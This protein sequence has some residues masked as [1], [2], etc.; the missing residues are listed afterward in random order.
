MIDAKHVL[1]EEQALTETAASENILDFLAAQDPGIGGGT[2]VRV[3]FQV[4]TELDSA[5]DGASLTIHVVD[6]TAAPVDGSSTV[7]VSSEAIAEASLVAGYRKEL[8][9]PAEAHGRILGLYYEVTG[10]D[11]TSGTVNAWVEAL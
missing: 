8:V 4:E 10:E 9:V 5:A 6:D 1:S 2:A 7:I 3:V 11:F